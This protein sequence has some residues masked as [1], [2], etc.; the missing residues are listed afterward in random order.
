ML[1]LVPVLCTADGLRTGDIMPVL[2]PVAVNARAGNCSCAANGLCA[3]DSAAI[4]GLGMMLFAGGVV[5]AVMAAED[6]GVCYPFRSFQTG[7]MQ[8]A[9][10]FL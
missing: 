1:V 3:G 7:L 4:A 9:T 10:G 5:V 2:M 8:Q 6:A